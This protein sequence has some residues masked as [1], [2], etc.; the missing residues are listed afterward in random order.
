MAWGAL[1]RSRGALPLETS[2][3][4]RAMGSAR[5]GV[6]SGWPER[7]AARMTSPAELKLETRESGY[8][9]VRVDNAGNRSEMLLSEE[10]VVTLAQSAPMLIDHVL[11]QRSRGTVQ[12]RR[13]TQ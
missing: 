8:A 2:I 1:A 11:A 13:L 6:V 3:R 10:N 7:K 12:A 5:A 9:L 4:S